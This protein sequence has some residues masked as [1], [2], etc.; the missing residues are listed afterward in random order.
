MRKGSGFNYIDPELHAL[1]TCTYPKAIPFNGNFAA[2]GDK[3]G[4]SVIDSTG[5]S[6][7]YP[8][9]GA[10]TSL[11]PSL[12]QTGKQALS[13]IFD[14]SGKLIIPV[15]YERINFLPHHIIQVIKEGEVR[16]FRTDGSELF[17]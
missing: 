8:N 11:T 14:T 15:N 16:Y 12:F 4:W 10:I 3:R 9:F 6:M 17:P 1:T 7:C 2:V 5:K 13:G